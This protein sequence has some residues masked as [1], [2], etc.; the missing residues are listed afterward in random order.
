[1]LPV[2]TSRVT[3]AVV[4]D[5]E[6]A[7]LFLGG[8]DVL[9]N[10]QPNLVNAGDPDRPNTVL[11]TQVVDD[12]GRRAVE[13]GDAADAG[14]VREDVKEASPSGDDPGTFALVDWALEN[15]TGSWEAER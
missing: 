1:M 9:G 11:R 15:G 14:V 13:G 10:A 4:S 8:V 3:P 6:R 5:V 7:E 12:L 2:Q